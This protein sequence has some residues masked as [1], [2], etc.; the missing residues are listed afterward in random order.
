[1]FRPCPGR[2][3]LA[4]LLSVLAAVVPILMFAA[5][6]TSSSNV[7][8]QHNDVNRTGQYVVENTLTPK[9]VYLGTST[10]NF[11]WLYNRSVD[12]AIYS[13]PLYVHS[14][15]A[16]RGH[17]N[18]FFITTENN[19]VYAFDADDLSSAASPIFSRQ[20][21]PAGPSSVCAETYS[22]R[23]GIT[24]TPVIDDSANVM[25]VVARNSNDHKHYL[26][27][28]N[29]TN[30]FNDLA[31]PRQIG[32][33]DPHGVSFNGECERNRPGLLLVHGVVYA[34]FGTFSCDAPCSSTEPYHGWVMGYHASDLSPAAIFCT[35]CTPGGNQAGIWQTG[36]G[37]VSD[38]SYVYF[39][40]GNGP[41]PLGDSFVQLQI[42]NS[43]PGLNL[44]GSYTPTNATTLNN[45]DTDLGS[46]GP[47]W[48]PG[49]ML[50]GGGKQGRY[51]LINTS[52]M[53]LAQDP[54]PH[55]PGSFDGFQAFTNTYHSD[56]SQAACS[57]AGGAAGCHIVGSCYVDVSRY[58][59]GELCGPNIHST[60]VFWT[61]AGSGFGLIYQM[62]EK[63]YL[64]SFTYNNSTNVLDESPHAISYARPPDGM[65]GGFSSLSANGNSSG[66]VWTNIP[67][68]DAQW[69]AVPG[70][71][72]AFDAL[73]LVE[74]WHDDGGYIF[75]KSVPPTVAEGKVIRATGSGMVVVYG[76]K[77]P[78]WWYKIIH[79]LFK[80]NPPPYPE[81]DGSRAVEELAQRYGGARGLLGS[82]VGGARPLNDA[83]GG[84]AQDFKSTV[85]LTHANAV[86]VHP[87]PLPYIPT[88]SHPPA[89]GSGT[90]IESSIYWSKQTKAHW[91]AG[92][93]RAFWLAHGG[94][95]GALGYPTSD[96]MPSPDG[97]G[98]VSHFHHGDVV[99]YVDKG[100]VAGSP[101]QPGSAKGEM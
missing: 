40:T 46:G 50:M 80:P 31:T 59:N 23:V 72:A 58:G 70:R 76:L 64:K 90:V 32:G 60:P 55:P 74:L 83:A 38:G 78:P 30:N 77:T 71:L 44:T 85:I 6:T 81:P 68:G 79:Y 5:C 98:R 28:L 4:R 39:E 15:P 9:T 13:Q 65:P 17:L 1:M 43:W 54:S 10:E 7:V 100:A 94:A 48:L 91:V 57:P 82:P 92:D 33:T 37:L 14:V 56:S 27:K 16:S 66:I 29:I 20:L 11:A 12:G 93:I 26:H 69:A 45:G 53:T 34:A 86:S 22:G 42:T 87:A 24:G 18:L 21:Q 73:S 62:P 8:T 96:E 41:P 101:Q 89:P 67:L 19:W 52:G 75:A 35:S 95:S 88:C 51:Y 36:G 99:W 2:I 63:D 25:Y 84:W 49:G 61:L 97:Q 47:V 3:T